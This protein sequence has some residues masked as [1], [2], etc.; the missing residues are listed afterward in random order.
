M[1]IGILAAQVQR[2][3]CHLLET[4]YVPV[5]KRVLRRLLALAEQY[6]AE[7]AHTVVIPLT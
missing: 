5:E 1:L 6:A 3:S 7:G 4:L 2:L